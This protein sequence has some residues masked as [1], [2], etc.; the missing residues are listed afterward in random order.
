MAAQDDSSE[1]E[2]NGSAVHDLPSHQRSSA[3]APSDER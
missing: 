2:R 1:W 3:L